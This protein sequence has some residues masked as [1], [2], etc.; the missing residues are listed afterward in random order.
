MEFL[1]VD[2][3]STYHGVLG[4]PVIK[5]LGAAIFAHHVCMKFPIEHEIAQ[6][7]MT[8]EEYKSAT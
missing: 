4:R 3:M 5:D 2:N 6:L 1:V 8:K 7:G